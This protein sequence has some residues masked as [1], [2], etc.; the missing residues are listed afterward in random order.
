MRAE[1]F[2][3]IQVTVSALAVPLP[4]TTV[5]IGGRWAWTL[6]AVLVAGLA[7]LTGARWLDGNVRHETVIQQ[8]VGPE[9]FSADRHAA[10][11]PDPGDDL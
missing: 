2:Y 8:P 7:L 5:L 1:K 11:A 10:T 3:S 6:G 4:T 9:D